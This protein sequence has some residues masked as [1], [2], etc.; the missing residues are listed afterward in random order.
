MITTKEFKVG[1]YVLLDDKTMRIEELF[2]GKKTH[3]DTD[4]VYANLLHLNG[5]KYGV[6][7]SI[8]DLAPLPIERK[9]L[10]KIRFDQIGEFHYTLN[11]FMV[12]MEGE[13]PKFIY[14]ENIIE[15]IEGFQQLQNHYFDFTG[16]ELPDAFK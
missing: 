4:G 5:N 16:A 11:N 8:K 14:G 6:G 7:R 9:H 13:K 15:G 3:Y 2:E 1:N 12:N 10:I